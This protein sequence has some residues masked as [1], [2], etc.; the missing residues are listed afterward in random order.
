MGMASLLVNAVTPAGARPMML[1]SN[2]ENSGSYVG[3]SGVRA[4]ASAEKSRS[5][6]TMGGPVLSSAARAKFGGNRAR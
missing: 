6:K 2:G 4:G 5:S 3:S 1:L